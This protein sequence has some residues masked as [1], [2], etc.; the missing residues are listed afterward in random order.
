MDSLAERLLERGIDD[1]VQP[2]PDPTVERKQPLL[3]SLLAQ[4]TYR[5]GT[6]RV[7]PTLRVERISGA[8]RV[9]LQDHA[10]HQQIAATSETLGGLAAALERAMTRPEPDW[11]PYKSPMVKDPAKRVKRRNP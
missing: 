7:L 1:R 3:W 5:D 8:Y 11:R 10:S 2:P 4:H 6:I 9:T